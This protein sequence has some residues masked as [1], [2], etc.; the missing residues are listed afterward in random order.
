MNASEGIPL[1]LAANRVYS[2]RA[3]SW[4]RR[5]DCAHAWEAEH[6]LGDLVA[7][8]QAKGVEAPNLALAYSHLQAYDRRRLAASA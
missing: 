5:F 4:G 8:A 1:S 3:S 2:V 6:I 7:R